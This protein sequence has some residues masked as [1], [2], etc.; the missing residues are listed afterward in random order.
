M[1][2]III[3]RL[4][5]KIRKVDSG[6]LPAFEDFV[7]DIY[8]HLFEQFQFSSVYFR[9]FPPNSSMLVNTYRTFPATTLKNY[10]DFAFTLIFNNHYS[11]LVVLS[12][13]IGLVLVH[14]VYHD[15]V[16]VC[17]VGGIGKSTKACLQYHYQLQLPLLIS[18]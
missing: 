13:A 10:K 4:D 16:Q 3:L 15:Y 18:L 2:V 17:S 5:R 12:Y 6:V 11:K 8:F 14:E 7:V 1:K 9:I